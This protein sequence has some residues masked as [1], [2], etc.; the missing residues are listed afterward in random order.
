MGP[1]HAGVDV[2]L[3]DALALQA[4]A[5]PELVGLGIGDAPVK[6]G[7]GQRCLGLDGIQFID[8]RGAHE[9]DAGQ[10]RQGVGGPHVA[11]PYI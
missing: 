3:D 6:S 1:V 8:L 4:K 9:P 2:G 7:I 11:A 10:R 5:G